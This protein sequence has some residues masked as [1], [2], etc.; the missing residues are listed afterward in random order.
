MNK[1][2]MDT[3]NENAHE[4]ENNANSKRVHFERLR[5]VLKFAG[6]LIHFGPFEAI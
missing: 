2:W 3:Y 1:N 4:K 5:G 6:G